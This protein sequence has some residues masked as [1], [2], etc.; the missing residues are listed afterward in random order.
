MIPACAG[1]LRLFRKRLSALLVGVLLLTLTPLVVPTNIAPQAKASLPECSTA[2]YTK[3]GSGLTITPS[4]GQVMYIDTGVSPKIDAAYV[5]YRI[6]NNTG[7]TVSGYWVSL[8]DFRGGVVSLA[9]VADANQQLLDSSSPLP[10]VANGATKTVYFLVK[11]NSSTKSA[12]SHTVS[13]YTGRPDAAGATPLSQCDFSFSKVAETIKAAANK[14][15]S[16]SVITSGSLQAGQLI[17][18]EVKGATG[19]VGAGQAPDFRLLWFSP[20]AFSNFPTRAIRLESVQLVTSPDNANFNASA[21]IRI[22]DER[23]LVKNDISPESSA[24]S[25]LTYAG[26]TGNYGRL[27]S[28][29]DALDGKRYYKNVYRFRVIGKSSTAATISPVSQISSGTQIKHTDL[30]TSQSAAIQTQNVVNPLTIT[31]GLSTGSFYAGTGSYAN[32]V[33]ASYQVTVNSN[34]SAELA[35]E[36][37]VDTPPSNAIF[38]GSAS[39]RI[40]SGSSLAI[41][42]IRI[43]SESGQNPQPYHFIGPFRVTSSASITINY[44]M[45]IPLTAGTYS[46]TAKA[47]IGETTITASSG[48]QVPGVQIVTDGSTVSSVGSTTV[49]LNPEP[50]TLPA[51]V[52]SGSSYLLGTVDANNQASAI[53]FEFG[54]NSSLST[55][56]SLTVGS[57]SSSTSVGYSY[58]FSGSAGTTY[59]F[60]I[61]A[62]TYSSSTR[63][64]GDILNFTT[65][66]PVGT[67]S[68]TTNTPVSVGSTTATIAGQ[69]DPNLNTMTEIRFKIST[70]S[71]T[72]GVGSGSA[73]TLSSGSTL[74]F[75]DLDESGSVVGNTTANGSSPT[76]FLWDLTG[77]TQGQTYYYQIEAVYSGGTVVGGVKS[78]KTGTSPQTITFSAGS[79]IVITANSKLVSGS[80][81]SG[82]APTYASDSPDY[83]SVNSSS[84][85]VTFINV[86]TCTITASQ[87]GD[88]TY[89]A[90]QEVTDSFEILPSAP[91]ATTNA[92]TSV[93][94]R[95]AT[96]NGSVNVGGASSTDVHFLYSTTEAEVTAGSGGTRVDASVSPISENGSSSYNLTD[97][98]VGTTYFYRI[99]ATNTTGTAAGSVVSFSTLTLTSRTL[100]LSVASATLVFGAGTF[101][102]SATPSA[103]EDDG[104][105]TWSS[106]STGVCTVV[107]STGVVTIVSAGTCL[108]D[109]S[110]SSGSTYAAA[111]ATQLSLTISPKPI[112]I[113]ADDKNCN[114]CAT[115]ETLTYTKSADLVGS[116]AIGSLTYT[117]TSASPSYNSTTTPTASVG[118]SG[119]Y[120]NTPSAAV[121]SSG[122]S[123][124]YNFTYVAGTYTVTTLANQTITFTTG[125]TETYKTPFMVSATVSSGSAVTFA[126]SGDCTAAAPLTVPSGTGTVTITPTAH[127]TNNCTITASQP[128]GGTFGAASPVSQIISIAKAI[129]DIFADGKTRTFGQSAPT[130]SYSTGSLKSGDDFGSSITTAPTCTSDYTASTS[131]GSSP[132]VISCSGG[133]S[134]N[135]SFN[136]VSGSL[137][138]TP[139]DQ[140]ITFTQPSNM[141]EGDSNQSLTVSVDSGLALTITSNST[142]V[143]TVSG[144]EV[145]AVSSGT[146]SLTASQGGNVDY[147]AASSVTVTFTINPSGG[148]GGTGGGTGGG[149][150]GST[151]GGATP[152][153]PRIESI[154][155]LQICSTGN[156]ILIIGLYFDGASV[157]LDGASV[158]IRNI[159]ST[160]I[161]V[162]L[163][164]A[165]AGKRTIRVTTP[166]GSDI[167][168]I[169]Y[170]SV[171]NPAFQATRIPY[172]SQGQAVVFSVNAT[173]ALSYSIDGRLP[174]G[175][176][177]NPKTGQI[178]GTPFENGIFVFEVVATGLCGN[179]SQFME[180]D[181]DAPTPNAISHRI[182]FLP[183]SCDIPDSAEASLQ[184][185]LEEAK[186][187]S[188]RNIIPEIY[189]SGGFKSGDPD[190]ELAKCRQNAICDFLLLEE[191]LGQV[192]TDVF[193]GSENRIEIIVYWPRPNDD[194]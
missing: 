108:L 43:D 119:T 34:S 9:N 165:V 135:Y 30:A 82:L 121:L 169:E 36:E 56:T 35:V 44:Q 16:V 95:S 69:V 137:V 103:G 3:S 155:R 105:K 153:A 47:V 188:P 91:T 152:P 132:L 160:N 19:I 176:M 124:N 184:R 74:I 148:G 29:A 7:A 156:E 57:S 115:A 178:S 31:K 8:T 37:I 104:T 162:S 93:G 130:Y 107:S 151:G 62:T 79:D 143:C 13:I 118:G 99:E 168:I 128:G 48:Y 70:S 94:Q 76:D 25:L 60:R 18:V 123:S 102:T 89:S 40:G 21:D 45:Y 161:S 113:T 147:N 73:L 1:D 142:S 175:L 33:R 97:L 131:V 84:G 138:I 129:L 174:G 2:G 154:S 77:L 112:T 51:S 5:G 23:L 55:Y 58:L 98:T 127:G 171:P 141:T 4:H 150:G 42:P 140:T 26:Y 172:I 185:F 92:A 144:T 101:N 80:T 181:V 191:L 117:F 64:T 39:Y 109:A 10:E 63:Y 100:T 24:S 27:L 179:T 186:G 163:P 6:T 190:S 158:L 11:A 183:G 67:P 173:G 52:T 41:T 106:A 122:S 111:N 78:F 133:V 68:A 126:T 166:N 28:T 81:S 136:Y 120:T 90:A 177:L 159:T 189:V 54:T 15:T 87:T 38:T 14:V 66:E 192:L 110:I 182:N 49:T 170:V 22:Y 20:A 86:G 50:V 157:T 59:Y 75:Q 17:T 164:A 167:A 146:C 193:T 61:V 71:T 85:L 187:I 145:V 149:S 72:T 180:L 88:A 139:A 65:Y 53:T 32:Y 96:M 116:D 83:C 125:S 194:L 114:N 12:Q 46:N 134:S